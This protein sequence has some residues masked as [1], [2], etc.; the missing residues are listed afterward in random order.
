MTE[1]LRRFNVVNVRISVSLEV[2]N[3]RLG[4]VTELNLMTF[5]NYLRG[6]QGPCESDSIF[7][8]S[9]GMNDIAK[10]YFPVAQ[11]S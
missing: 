5:F 11:R 2:E 3:N 10:C 1:A 7:D 6:A 8:T 9:E 4:W